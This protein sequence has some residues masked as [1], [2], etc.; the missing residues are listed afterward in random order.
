MKVKNTQDLPMY[1]NCVR[2][3]Q[4][5]PIG[6][7]CSQCKERPLMEGGVATG[8]VRQIYRLYQVEDMFFDSRLIAEIHG[9]GHDVAKADT[10]H[11]PGELVRDLNII[12]LNKLH[13]RL[14]GERDGEYWSK[15]EDFS[16]IAVN[17]QTLMK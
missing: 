12:P 13:I 14:N 15:D 3:G 8:T 9:K 5:R 16:D 6:T 10:W 11:R 2:C 7:E 1:G 17:M 4:G